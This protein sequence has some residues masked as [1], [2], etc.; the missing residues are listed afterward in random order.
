MC[1]AAGSAILPDSVLP[2]SPMASTPSWSAWSR[3]ERSV[4]R[5]LWPI[6]RTRTGWRGDSPPHRSS[7]PVSVSRLRSFSP[8]LFHY[9]SSVATHSDER[10]LDFEEARRTVEEHAAQLRPRGRELLSLLDANG[11]VLAEPLHADRDFPPFP[12]A[13]RDGYAVRAADLEN[14]PASLEVIG[15]IKAGAPPEQLPTIAP[16]KAAAI[17]TGATAPAGADAVIMVE[18]TARA[19]ERVEIGRS[20]VAGGKNVSQLDRG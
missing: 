15:E 8:G 14:L 7:R 17:M 5:P 16:G 3:A 19:G 10:V 6:A 18:Y 12:R 13:A 11:R 2:A 4:P 20:V 1:A 9:H